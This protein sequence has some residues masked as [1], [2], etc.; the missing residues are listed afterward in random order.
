MYAPPGNPS[1]RMPFQPGMTTPSSGSS[2]TGVCIR[3]PADS[4]GSTFSSS[5]KEEGPTGV[6]WDNPYAEWYLNSS[7]LIGQ[8]GPGCTN[9]RPH[10]G[11][12]L[13]RLPV[14]AFDDGPPRPQGATGCRD[15]GAGYVVLTTKHHDGFCLWPTAPGA[16]AQRA[17]P[18]APRHRRRPGRAITRCGLGWA[19]TTRA[20]KTGSFNDALRQ[21]P[22][23]ALAVP[24]PVLTSH[25]PHTMS[26]S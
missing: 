5:S 17:P 8:S 19:C 13:R 7:R 21:N 24:H 23:T 26:V 1:R 3:C 15:A 10:T 2:F 20:A 18:R 22:R 25:T 12:H 9:G 4:A 6:L 16:S 14:G 11:C